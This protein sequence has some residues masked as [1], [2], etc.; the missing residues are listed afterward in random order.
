M[1]TSGISGKGMAALVVEAGSIAELRVGDSSEL[2]QV[3]ATMGSSDGCQY[4]HVKSTKPGGFDKSMIALGQQR[5][6]MIRLLAKGAKAD[7]MICRMDML[8]MGANQMLMELA[9]PVSVVATGEKGGPN[10]RM[11]PVNMVT[12]PVMKMEAM[13]RMTA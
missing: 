4:L 7:V 12:L 8:S 6:M 5:G 3:V 13:D 9:V 1:E 2:V 10:G 11:S